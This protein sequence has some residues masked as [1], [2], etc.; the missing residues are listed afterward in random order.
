V[1]GNPKFTTTASIRLREVNPNRRLQRIPAGCT[2]GSSATGPVSKLKSETL[3]E[4]PESV[5]N[6]SDVLKSATASC[7]TLDASMTETV[8]SRPFVRI[9]QNVERLRCFLELLH[10]LVVPRI[11]VR[12]KL[13]RQLLI[14][15]FQFFGGRG[16]GHP[17]NF[18][19]VTLC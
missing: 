14:S 6:V 15:F 9:V 12:M 11:S 10:G 7:G 3:E 8:I 17:E 2:T 19:V 4:I 18:V 5:E 16:A 13:R 1:T